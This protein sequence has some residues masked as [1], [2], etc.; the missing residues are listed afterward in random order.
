MV[1]GG[2]YWLCRLK[3]VRLS[4]SVFV[5]DALGYTCI[6]GISPEL[7][8]VQWVHRRS[9]KQEVPNGLLDMVVPVS[10]KA[11]LASEMLEGMGT[12]CKS[13]GAQKPD[14]KFSVVAKPL[15]YA[16]SQPCGGEPYEG[17]PDT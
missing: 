8:V 6:S 12:S 13:S 2:K 1:V 5:L 17:V 10:A 14:V 9:G 4:T 11:A 16:S 15:A 7:V 3:P